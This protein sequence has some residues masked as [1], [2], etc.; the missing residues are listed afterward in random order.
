MDTDKLKQIIKIFEGSQISK[1]DLQ[2]GDLKLVLEKNITVAPSINKEEKI[3]EVKET[4]HGYE[5]KSPL[6]GTFYSSSEQGGTP[7]VKI[8]DKVNAG[9]TLC[10]IEAMK[11]MNEI[12]SDRSGIVQD[13]LVK[14]EE[15][16]EYDQVL[17]VI[18]DD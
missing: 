9:D 8:G 5:M 15:S 11:V 4:S 16:V 2:D 10:I 17:M 14:N 18:S 3:E 6:V 12:K 13:I 7:F 1:L